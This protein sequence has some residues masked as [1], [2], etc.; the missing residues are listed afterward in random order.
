M[1]QAC[2][3]GWLC[4][5]GLFTASIATAAQDEAA[6]K[7][8]GQDNVQQ[9]QPATELPEVLVIGR[10]SKDGVPVV[11]L[12]SV[13]SRD[14]FGPDQVRETGA[15]DVND[16]LQN[17]P[18]ISARPYNGGEA[19]A[20]SFSM[21]GL[22]D[23]GL[24]EYVHVLIDGVPASP[25]PY[26]WTAF[27]FLPLTPDRIYAVDFI[28]GG[29]SV[30]YSPDTVGG[31]VN[32]ITRPIPEGREY[33][34]RS[35]VG[36]FDYSSTLLSVGDSD[37]KLG[38]AATY[39]DRRGS[40]YRKD[41][42]FD[43]QDMNF[44][45]R[46]ELEPGDWWALSLSYIDSEHKAPG[47]LT[48]EQFEQDRFGNSRTPNR[49][50]GSRAVADFVLHREVDPNT[51]VESYSYGS[52]TRRNLVAQRPQYPDVGDTLT[53]SDWNDDS[54]VL[55]VGSRAEH[56]FE[57]FGMEHTLYGGVRYQ[58]EWIPEWSIETRPLGG[59]AG[60]LLMED[61]YSLDAF[62]MNIDDTF[63]PVERLTVTGGLRFE[64]IPNARGESRV[65]SGAF[66]F[67]EQFSKV[68]PGIGA[69]Y[70]LSDEWAVFGN[71]HQ[72][73]RAPQMWGF[74]L[75]P[76]PANADIDF[77]TADTWE[78]GARYD[79]AEG[80]AASV[81]A[82]RN[83]YESFFVFDTGFYENLGAIEAEGVD[84][85]GTLAVPGV[86]GLTLLA[87]VTYQDSLLSSGP[88][89]GNEV[90]YAWQ[91]KAAWRLR[92]AF[93]TGWVASFGGTYVGE[94]FSDELNT[95]EENPNGNLGLNPSRTLWDA[96]LARAWNIGTRGRLRLSVG[97][98]N[99]FDQD[100]HVHSRGGFFGGGKVAGPPRQA[101]F[102]VTYTL[103]I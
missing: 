101:Y 15:R 16:L 66:T 41:G 19:A 62:S 30:R 95:V 75:T 71:Y 69:S 53:V 82:W 13:G 68:L 61:K 14:V 88:N 37:G 73:F 28:R 29:H 78:L 23:D 99:L 17:L 103:G 24:T 21:R 63:H 74:G 100:W 43:Q 52:L 92:Y 97:A 94:S 18:A 33:E 31:V 3:G 9:D 60:T 57:A 64:Y 27:S 8:Q 11:P 65:G 56:R 32:F 36:D 85:E 38:W 79:D 12:D 91:Q 22:P 10:R 70:R 81:T 7:E 4:V 40:G 44:K 87:S 55:G 1:D 98:T 51:W 102:G 77:E 42:G 86:E 20:P 59:G 46:R 47:G 50:Q 25:Q 83:R 39:V 45:L 5:F 48:L 34:V 6:H 26:G 58:R 84:L 67:N 72:G 49:F 80:L 93:D 90:P 96:Q 35:T 2:C 89:D 54:F 76:D